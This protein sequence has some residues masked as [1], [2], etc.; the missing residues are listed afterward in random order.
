MTI[1]KGSYPWGAADQANQDGQNQVIQHAR[2]FL[3][4]TLPSV[5]S[6]KMDRSDYQW[7]D[8]AVNLSA[9]KAISAFKDMEIERI[10]IFAAP[11]SRSVSLLS[12]YIEIIPT[13]A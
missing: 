11:N 5:S 13:L 10:Q 6:A 12:D 4:R 8:A 7:I 9:I 1:R 3:E 2:V